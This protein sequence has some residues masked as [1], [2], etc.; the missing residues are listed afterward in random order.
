MLDFLSKLFA[1]GKTGVDVNVVVLGKVM[2]GANFLKY[3]RFVLNTI[4]TVS[5]WNVYLPFI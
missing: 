1:N 3:S 4:A 2:T 5:L